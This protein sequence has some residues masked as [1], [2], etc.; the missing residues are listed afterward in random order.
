[1]SHMPAEERRA[2]RPPTPNP[3]PL[4]PAPEAPDAK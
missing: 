1:M 4:T 3:H 2:A